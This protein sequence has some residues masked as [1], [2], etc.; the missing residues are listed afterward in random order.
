[1]IRLLKFSLCRRT[2]LLCFCLIPAVAAAQNQSEHVFKVPRAD[3]EKALSTLHATAPGRLPILDGFVA[4]EVSG[5]EKYHRAYYQYKL[6]IHPAET[7]SV[8]LRVSAKVTAWY[9]G[10]TAN[11]AGYRVLPSDGRLETDLIERLEEALQQTPQQTTTDVARDNLSKHGSQQAVSDHASTPA[12]ATPP[13]RSSTLGLK[14]PLPQP[15]SRSSLEPPDSRELAQQKR[16]QQLNEQAANLEEILK[17]QASPND[18]AAVLKTGT[19]V[20]AK[21]LDAGEVLFQADAEDEFKVLDQSAGWVHVQVSG[22]SRGWIRRADL[23]MPGESVAAVELKP[24]ASIQPETHEE[25][26]LFPGEWTPLRGH[27]VRIT[28]VRP[29]A[30]ATAMDRWQLARSVFRATYDHITHDNLKIDGVVLVID[31]AD[32]GM[33]AATISSL[34][35]WNTGAITDAAFRK[36]CWADSP[37]AL[38]ETSHRESDS[39]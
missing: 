3:L 13:A 15:S 22:I 35:R 33:I 24:A 20:F 28:W 7:G 39:Q 11:P 36:E 38:G 9:S 37:E 21:P 6:E 16:F 5:L 30:G 31:S 19:P 29:Q 25:T 34:Q 23:E 17:N 32:G 27:L 26:S 4:P 10:D 14:L 18:L 1:M 8:S 2:L 12:R